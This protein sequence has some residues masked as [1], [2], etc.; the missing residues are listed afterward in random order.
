MI[1]V[2]TSKE[3]RNNKIIK[4]EIRLGMKPINI[5]LFEI[6]FFISQLIAPIKTNIIN[7]K[8]II[9]SFIMLGLNQY[10]KN[11]SNKIIINGE[12]PK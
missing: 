11:L 9:K 5:N 3:Y 8:N 2:N 6:F 12:I 4:T 7:E 1:N 10:K